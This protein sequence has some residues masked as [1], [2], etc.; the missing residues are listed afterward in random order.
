MQMPPL[1]AFTILLIASQSFAK[2]ASVQF[3]D[4]VT[5]CDLVV[6]AKV[7]S[8]SSPL[9]GKKY[10]KAR[11][12]EVWKGATTNAV[13]FLASPTWTCDISEARKGETILLFLTKSTK[14]RSYAIAH[15]GRGRLPL[16]TVGG[17]GYATFWGDI[18]LPKE[19]PTI[20]GPDPK[21]DFVRSVEI[22]I[23]RDL[24]KN[25]SQK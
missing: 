19:V 2:V 1:I 22:T 8:V 24:V 16:R 17:K 9:M 13:E 15:S 3:S 11:V 7:D 18:I 5:N 10:A 25:A 20:D 6:I 14:S 23:L 12:T 4:L 21:W